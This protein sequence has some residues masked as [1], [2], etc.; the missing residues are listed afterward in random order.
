MSA[1]TLQQQAI[2]DAQRQ[3]AAVMR[4]NAELIRVYRRLTAQLADALEKWDADE[5]GRLKSTLG[6]LARVFALRRQ[7][8]RMLKAAGYDALAEDVLGQS[9]DALAA[10][11]VRAGRVPV[12]LGPKVEKVLEAWKDLRLA[13]LFDLADSVARSLQRVALDGT[14]GLR[15]MSKLVRDVALTLERSERQART[16]VDTA[17]ST[18]SRQMEQL[19]ATGEPDE[20]F[21]YVG[22]VDEK[23]RP[24]CRELIGKVRTRA[25]IDRLDNGQLPNVLLTGGGYNCRHLMKRVSKL[26]E[27]LIAIAGTDERAPGVADLVSKVAA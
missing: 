11:A 7:A 3:D 17:V 25:A 13:D 18:F 6:N 8:R 10:S 20:L 16:I 4:F 21:V 15:P 1:K 23:M 12:G 2:R 22:P 26:D 9:L 19:D 27:E 24:F 14:L 5:T